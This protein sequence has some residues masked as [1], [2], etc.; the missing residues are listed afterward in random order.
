MKFVSHN[1]VALS[2]ALILKFPPLGVVVSVLAST[3]PDTVEFALRLKHRGFF[4]SFYVY[5]LLYTVILALP[6]NPVVDFIRNNSLHT[7]FFTGVVIGHLVADFLTM[8]P[9]GILPGVKGSLKLF[10]T[11]SIAEYL[12]VSVLAGAVIFRYILPV[13]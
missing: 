11:G 10:K 3:F 6:A 12:L 9:I 4:H 8:T 2:T 1:A 13:F 7:Y 5:G